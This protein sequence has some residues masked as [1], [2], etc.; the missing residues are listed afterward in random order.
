MRATVIGGGLAGITAALRLADA[1]AAVTLLEARPRLGGLTHSFRRSVA[2]QDLWIDN[3]Q[4][5]F[6]RCC[7]AYT[8]LLDRLGVRDQVELQPRLDVTVRSEASTRVGRLRRAT[9]PPPLHLAVALAGYPWL[10]LAAKARLVPAVVALGR[11]DRTAPTTDER[12]FGAWLA[13]HG[14]G[15]RAIEALWDLIGVA[16]LNATADR[17]SLALAA[18]VFQLG[19]LDSPDAADIGWA[20]VPLQQLHGDAATR[21]LAAAG[22]EVRTGSRMSSLQGIDTDALV[23]AVP[24]DQARRLLPTDA[25]DLPDGWV[26]G[27]GSAPILNL[28]LVYDRAVLEEPFT[29]AVDSPLQWV[30]DRTGHS[31]LSQGQYVAVSLSAAQAYAELPVAELRTRFLPHVEALLPRARGAQLL[32]FFVTR[33]PHATFDPTPGTAR[34]RPP[35][36]TRR[37]GLYVAGAWTATGWP[38]TMEGAVRS[39]NDAAA[40]VLEDQPSRLEVV[41]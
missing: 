32:D 30:F 9:L 38:A 24:P 37:R 19:L 41:A 31:G 12:S 33:E 7:T 8:D 1:G 27:L 23:L 34:F 28:H 18:T 6:L 10:G 29:A 14:Q 3:G 13:D 35:A 36:R 16:T 25:L 21:A 5:V 17:A 26:E 15:A 22:V 20:R 40:A 2:D 39:G 4:H 11:L